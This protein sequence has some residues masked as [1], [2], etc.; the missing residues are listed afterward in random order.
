MGSVVRRGSRDSSIK[1]KD[2]DGRWNMRRPHQPTREQAKQYLREV[3]A[4][5]ARGLVGI[6]AA[7]ARLGRPTGARCAGAGRP[8]SRSRFANSERQRR[9][10]ML[11]P[12]W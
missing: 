10:G 1:Y 9:A 5:V 6:E 2:V 12:S 4:R 7:G 11:S 8:G 3:E